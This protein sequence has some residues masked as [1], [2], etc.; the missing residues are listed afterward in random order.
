LLSR[1]DL[2]ISRDAAIEAL[3]PDVTLSAG[4]ARLSNALW[5]L[6]AAL[7]SPLPASLARH[8]TSLVQASKGLLTLRATAGMP[9]GPSQC[10][11]DVLAFEAQCTELRRGATPGEAMQAAEAALALYRGHLL[12]EAVGEVW[13]D[14]RRDEL[15]LRWIESAF[16]RA[17]LAHAAGQ[18]HAALDPL[19]RVLED[20]PDHV[21]AACAAM[22]VLAQMGR[23]HDALRLHD[24]VRSECL[25][26]DQGYPEALRQAAMAV[27]S[28]ARTADKTNSGPW[29]APR[30]GRGIRQPV[31]R[32]L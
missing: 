30:D 18:W 6:R 16:H 20:T 28:G 5:H 4:S 14:R 27:R 15:R 24:R 23:G 31:A 17:D 11:L 21:D 10:W 12:P 2:Q 25:R 22:D 26:T 29:G 3:W 13:V 9:V 8:A 1:P 7:A 32:P 19:F